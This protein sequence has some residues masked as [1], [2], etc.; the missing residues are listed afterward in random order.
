MPIIEDVLHSLGIVTLSK[1]NF[2]ADDIVATLVTQARG[3]FEIV[4]VTGDRD[5]LQLVDATTTVLYPTRG[6]STLTRF[7]P[8]EVERK[9]GLTPEQY[10]DYAALRGDPSDNLPSVPK[11]GEKTAC[12]L[13]TSPSPRDS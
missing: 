5:Y 2:E 9:Y 13:Y 12:L 8:E 6:V 7:T 11:V 4:I 3:D 10:P 1:E